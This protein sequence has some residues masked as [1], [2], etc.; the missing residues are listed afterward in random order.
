MRQCF[1]E[2]ERRLRLDFRGA[3]RSD[4]SDLSAVSV[5]GDCLFV[6]SDEGATVECLLRQGDGGYAYHATLDLTKLLKL[7]PELLKFQ[8][9]QK[10]QECQEAKVEMDIEGLDVDDNYLWVVGSHSLTRPKLKMKAHKQDQDKALE[11][12]KK[13]KRRPARH[14]LGRVPLVEIVPGAFEA[15]TRAKG[16]SGNERHSGYLK[17]TDGGNDLDLELQK[18]DYIHR[19]L[20]LPAKE[21]GFDIEGIAVTGN[22]VLLGL[23]GPVLR[24]WAILLQLDIEEN[25]AG[26]LSLTKTEPVGKRHLKHFLDLHGLGV[27]E[28]ARDGDELLILAG[29]TMDLDGPVMLYRWPGAL[30]QSEPQVVDHLKPVLN[31]PYGRGRD[32]AEGICLVPTD[33]GTKELLVVYDSPA[34]VRLHADTAIDADVFVLDHGSANGHRDRAAAGKPAPGS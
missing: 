28:L 31:L 10:C 9:S 15:R 12:L 34:N 17:M 2:P 3:D 22:R 6:A 11:C 23:R 7:S 18:D 33:D 21:N 5:H 24:G 14:L 1:A 16:K 13:V 29:P 26:Q 32:H 27:R 30:R 19:F 8:E 4:R 20:D 25:E